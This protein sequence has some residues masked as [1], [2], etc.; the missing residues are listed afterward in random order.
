M[1]KAVITSKIE[2]AEVRAAIKSKKKNSDPH[3]VPPAIWGNIVG[4]ATKI[5]PGP[6]SG[7][8]PSAKTV[9]KIAIPAIIAIM[10]SKRII[11]KAE[12][13]KS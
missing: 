6:E 12:D 9:A 7:L 8:A 4:S 1:K 5:K 11:H 2:I 3:S 13:N 10:V